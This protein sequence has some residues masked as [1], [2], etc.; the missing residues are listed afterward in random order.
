MREWRIRFGVDVIRSFFH[1]QILLFGVDAI[2]RAVVDM[3]E[4]ILDAEAIEFVEL[5]IQSCFAYKFWFL[6][7]KKGGHELA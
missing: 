3:H 2:F 7:L 5:K 4:V 6:V 1:L